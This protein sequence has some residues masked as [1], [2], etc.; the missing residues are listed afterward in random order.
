MFTW[1]IEIE[2]QNGTG[3]SSAHTDSE[4]ANIDKASEPGYFTD[5]YQ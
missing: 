4:Y 2:G 1:G 3:Y 5:R